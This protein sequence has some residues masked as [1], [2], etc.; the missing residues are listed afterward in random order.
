MSYNRPYGQGGYGQPGGGANS[1]RGPS[2]PRY[3][4]GGDRAQTGSGG[5]GGSGGYVQGSG[6]Y[7]QGGAQQYGGGGRAWGQGPP[8][9]GGGAR[10]GGYG[11]RGG[12]GGEGNYRGGYGGGQDGSGGGR[13]GGG[14]PGR[15]GGRGRGD[16]GRNPPPPPA[17]FVPIP[18]LAVVTP[19]TQQPND[20]GVRAPE[21]AAR[22]GYGTAGRAVNIVTNCFPLTIS[23]NYVHWFK[24]EVIIAAVPRARADGSAAPPRGP[25]PKSVLRAVWSALEQSELNNGAKTDGRLYFGGVMPAF[26]GRAAAYC[27]KM[28]PTGNNGAD[29]VHIASFPAPDRPNMTFSVTVRNPIPVPLASLRSYITGGLGATYKTADLAE[30][31]QALNVVLGYKPASLFYASRTSFFVSDEASRMLQQNGITGVSKESVEVARGFIELWR[32]FFESVRPCPQTLVV[33]INTTSTAFYKAG[34]LSMFVQGYFAAKNVRSPQLDVERLDNRDIVSI[35]RIIKKLAVV[36]DRGTNAPKLSLKLRGR[37]IVY[38]MPRNHVFDTADGR[39]NV[40]EYL[41]D[42][43]QIRLRNPRWPLV[44]VKAGTF[45]PMELICVVEG[46]KYMKRLSP[47]EQNLASEFQSL[48]PAAKLAAIL[49]ARRRIVGMVSEPFLTTFGISIDRVP[50]ETYGRILAPPAIEYK[51]PRS[52]AGRNPPAFTS[53][54]PQDGDWMI[55]F[56]RGCFEQQ[57]ILGAKLSSVVVVVPTER[58]KAATA[59][60]MNGLAQKLAGLGLDLSNFEP[61]RLLQAIHVR[62]HRDDVRST[63]ERAIQLGKAVYR[64]PQLDLIVWVFDEANSPE[65]HLFKKVATEFGVASQGLQSRLVSK[66]GVQVFVNVGMKINAKLAG[67]CHRLRVDTMGAWYKRHV[68]MIFMNLCHEP[69]RPSVAVVVASMHQ[70]GILYEETATVQG[71]VEPAD[72]N[73]ALNLVLPPLPRLTTARSARTGRAK[74][75]ETIVDLKDMVVFLLKRRITSVCKPP[76]DAILVFRDGISESEFS[77]VIAVELA[78]YHE[79]FRIVKADPDMAQLLSAQGADGKKALD[80][81]MPKVTMIATLKRHHI[82]AFVPD[83]Q[84]PLGEVS[85]ATNILPGTVFDRDVTDP[86]VMD[87]YGCGHKALIGTARATRYVVL[88]EEQLPRMSA[89]EVQQTCNALTHTYQRC[90]RAVSLPAPI[91]YADLLANRIRGWLPHEDDTASATGTYRSA[92]SSTREQDLVGARAILQ[93]TEAGRNAFRGDFA[94][95]KPPAMWWN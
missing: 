54:V 78:A 87:H 42:H 20:R 83:P 38:V 52:D 16:S 66:P 79:A 77:A 19:A 71:L 73:G 35:N 84:D 13:G 30:A 11:G 85:R 53:V 55:R 34:D 5:F 80:G 26:D 36:V 7:G 47:A 39:T 8:G 70:Q 1:G 95:R 4:G 12:R 44:E 33:N 27:S 59:S 28:I 3:G 72:P 14:G 75:Q 21:P 62:R 9:S 82:R 76:P 56:A 23:D 22:T 17:I 63:V 57:F 6:G 93:E 45:Y 40:E 61:Q 91:Y 74:K 67:Y 46:N 32:G 41:W 43:F 92:S 48:P 29:P 2:P 81:W 37:G 86:R 31:L 60:F 24:Y 65:Y 49:T 18:P 89:D 68:P 64:Q 94:T 58:E 50:K 90:N 51:V 10:D 25:P 88:V 69:E 15:G